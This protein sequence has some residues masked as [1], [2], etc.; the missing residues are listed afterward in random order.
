[1]ETKT[2]SN[3]EVQPCC[4]D[5]SNRKVLESSMSKTVEQCKICGRK[6]YE[7]AVDPIR[8]GVKLS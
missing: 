8:V 7:F 1:M 2:V 4:Q 6:H 3:G 5:L